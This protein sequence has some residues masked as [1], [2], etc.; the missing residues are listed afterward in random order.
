MSEDDPHIAEILTF[1]E[2]IKAIDREI[3]KLYETRRRIQCEIVTRQKFCKH[4]WQRREPQYQSGM[5]HDCAICGA[6]K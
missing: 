1:R 2:E 3:S 4:E 6:W 5:Y